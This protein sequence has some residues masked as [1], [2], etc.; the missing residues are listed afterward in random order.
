[1]DLDLRKL[2]YFVAVAEELNFGRAAESLHITQPVLSRQIKALEGELKAQL[3][4]RDKRSTELT[5]AGRQLLADAGPL[6]A[7]AAGV[8]RRVGRAAR[9]ADSFT[10]GF[11]PGLLVTSAVRELSRRHPETTVEVL[12]T[13]WDDQVEVIHDGRVDIG[14][15][16]LPA[17]R[18]GLSVVPLLTEPRVVMLPAGHPLAAKESLS[19][20][21]LAGDHLLQ[22]PDAV[23]EWRD[24]A[25]RE[26]PR[27][28]P[29]P[30]MRTV[31][32]K[33]EYVAAG[34]GVVVL[35]LSTATF[36]RR[37]DVTTSRIDDIPDTQVCLAWERTRRTALIREFAGIAQEFA[38]STVGA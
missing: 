5:R 14:Y 16:R 37:P 34:T 26:P 11:M 25:R 13:G 1:M 3:F 18:Q 33:L 38:R 9:P 10:V 17:D 24:L 19:I 4:R 7:S 31:E 28:R 22:D 2:R 20:R 23:P 32:E 36:Y 30:A 8:R 6:L 21:D 27:T 29:V 12:R 15:I 35:P